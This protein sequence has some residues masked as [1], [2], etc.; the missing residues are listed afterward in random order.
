[1]SVDKDTCVSGCVCRLCILWGAFCV[2]E[3]IM[4]VLPVSGFR[5]HMRAL[6]I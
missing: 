5:V 1:M 6:N 4:F 3:S 2:C